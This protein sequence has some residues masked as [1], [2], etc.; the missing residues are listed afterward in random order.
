MV[1]FIIVVAVETKRIE[2]NQDIFIVELT[3]LGD[4]LDMSDK[5][6]KSKPILRFEQQG[7]CWYHLWG[8]GRHMEIKLGSW[9][10]EA[11]FFRYMKFE[12]PIKCPI[13][14]FK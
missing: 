3:G 7:E 5:K 2:W 1:D 6:K 4:R 14:D 10:L 11:L 13:E 8:C 9:E 12:M